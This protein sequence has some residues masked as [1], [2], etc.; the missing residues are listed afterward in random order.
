MTYICTKYYCTNQFFVIVL[1]IK[2]TFYI[3]E[4][5][6]R[7]FASPYY[8]YSPSTITTCEKPMLVAYEE[9]GVN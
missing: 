4:N 2:K 7:P 6:F 5:E 3:M 1:R 8:A 9:E